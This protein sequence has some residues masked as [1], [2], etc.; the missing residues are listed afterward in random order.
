MAAATTEALAANYVNGTAGVGATLT[1]AAPGVLTIDGYTVLANDRV[2]VKNQTS[3]MQNGI[4]TLTTAGTAAVPYVLTRATDF[5]KPADIVSGA[6]VPVQQGTVNRNERFAVTAQGAITIGTTVI[7]FGPASAPPARG[8]HNGPT[9]RR[10]IFPGSRCS[11][12]R[13]SSRPRRAM[14]PSACRR[15][16]TSRAS[17]PASTP[18]GACTRRRPTRRSSARSA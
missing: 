12:R 18:S 4:Y 9:A 13:P 2:L 11:I 16:G 14:A 15:A 3:A 5:D 7:T 8:R 10:G 6:V 17:T 1:A